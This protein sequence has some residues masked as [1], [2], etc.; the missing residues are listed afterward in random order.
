MILSQIATYN[1][2]NAWSDIIIPLICA[3]IGGG[4]TLLGVVFTIKHENEKARQDYSERIRPFIVTEDP[5]ITN[6]DIGKLKYVVVKNDDKNDNFPNERT[7]RLLAVLLSNA[8]EAVFTVDYIR[9]NGQKY[10]CYHK[11]SIVPNETVQLCGQ[12]HSGYYLEEVKNITIGVSDRQSKQYEYPFIF[13][14]G[15][16]EQNQSVTDPEHIVIK[17]IDCSRNLINEGECKKNGNN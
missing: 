3:I 6:K 17:Y 2:I 10:N 14:F 5:M 1:Q 13:E 4:L 8:G 7:Y 15:K 12:P 16:L 11:V 9:I